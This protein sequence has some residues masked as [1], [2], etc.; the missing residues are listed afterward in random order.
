MSVR[1]RTQS[2]GAVFL[3]IG[4]LALLVNAALLFSLWTDWRLDRAG[5]R[6]TAEV[7][8]TTTI[9]ENSADPDKFYVKYQLPREAD[10]EQQDF[11]A[12]VDSST[13]HEADVTGEIEATYL[14][15][16]PGANRVEGQVTGSLMLWLVG[17]CDLVLVFFGV[18]AWKFAPR[19]EKPLVLLATADVKR[20]RPGFSVHPAGDEFVVV[21]DVLRIEEGRVVIHVGNEAEVTIVLGEYQNPVGYQQPAEARGRVLED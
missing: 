5:V 2:R 13:W 15:G 4:L 14:Q 7:L 18:M 1:S 11:S 19:P 8:E 21:G 20:S 9:P 17:L 3:C 12:E 10:E 16:R 6:T